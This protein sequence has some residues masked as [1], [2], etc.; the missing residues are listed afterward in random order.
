M[1]VPSRVAEHAGG[2]RTHDL[3]GATVEECLEH[4]FQR[5]PELST[6]LKV[7]EVLGP[8]VML[9]Y[10]GQDLLR[11]H[12]ATTPATDSDELRIWFSCFYPPE[13]E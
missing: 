7:G 10:N 1:I 2:K 11:K 4:L 12:A 13:D 8:S 6:W 9:T 3:A 5:F